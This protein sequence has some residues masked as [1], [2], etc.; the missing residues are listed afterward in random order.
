VGKLHG[1]LAA[2]DLTYEVDFEPKAQLIV[3]HDQPTFGEMKAVP[4][5]S[6]T[7]SRWVDVLGRS[8]SSSGRR[9]TKSTA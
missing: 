7:L 1:R 6:Y 5:V 4:Q 2:N 9:A 8:K 3:H